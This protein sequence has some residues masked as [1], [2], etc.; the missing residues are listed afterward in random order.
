[1]EG[2]SVRRALKKLLLERKGRILLHNFLSVQVQALRGFLSFIFEDNEAGNDVKI[3]ALIDQ[4]RYRYVL[5]QG[6]EYF[7][8]KQWRSA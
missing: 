3:K 1:M 2:D 6:W 4:A 5:G 7:W 8:E